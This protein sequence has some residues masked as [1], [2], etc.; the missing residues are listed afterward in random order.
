MND[1]MACIFMNI[2]EIAR[3]NKSAISR[4]YGILYK[5]NHISAQDVVS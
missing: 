3:V 2:C 5:S 1:Y 4:I